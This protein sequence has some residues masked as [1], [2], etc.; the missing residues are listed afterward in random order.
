MA[1][2]STTLKPALEAGLR[3]FEKVL[4]VGKNRLKR[5]EK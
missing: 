2:F 5:G 4:M 3:H 1:F